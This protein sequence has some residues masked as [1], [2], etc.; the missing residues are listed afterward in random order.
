M[1][2]PRSIP[3]SPGRVGGA[4]PDASRGPRSIS[5][6]EAVEP[7]LHA[8]WLP[9][10]DRLVI[11]TFIE[12]SEGVNG[13][14]WDQLSAEE[15]FPTEGLDRNAQPKGG[16]IDADR[17][18]RARAR[19]PARRAG[20]GAWPGTTGGVAAILQSGETHLGRS[21]RDH[22]AARPVAR[23]ACRRSIRCR[24]PSSRQRS[25]G[26]ATAQA[27]WARSTCASRT[28]SGRTSPNGSAACPTRPTGGAPSTPGSA[29]SRRP[30][31]R[32]C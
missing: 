23:R 30:D 12:G 26:W 29:T 15:W 20:D 7:L 18:C 2:A 10:V 3:R 27:C 14:P 21:C 13:A 4:R 1:G 17:R 16:F 25:A 8:P 31:C 24:R 19:R 28:A 11:A 9:E 32:S 5:V 6:K 22:L